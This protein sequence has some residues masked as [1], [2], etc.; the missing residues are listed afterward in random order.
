MAQIPRIGV[1]LPTRGV[2]LK[3]QD[4]PQVEP[5]LMVAQRAEEVGCDSV[6]VGDSLIAKPRLEPL[7]TLAAVA[8]RTCRVRLGTAVLLAALRHP[9]LLAQTAATVDLLS[10]GRLTL[11]AGV[12]GTFTPAQRL[13]LQAAGVDPRRRARRLEEVIQIMRRLWAGD[14][15]TVRT[16]HFALE[17]ISLGFRPHQQHGIPILLACHSG[18]ARDAQCR[19]AARLADGIISITDPPEEFARVREQTL[20]E[21]QALGKDLQHFTAV[22]YMTVNVHHD[23]EAARREAV[24][25]VTRYYG[26]DYWGDRWGPYGPPETLAQRIHEYA[27]AGAT[28]VIV[29]FASDDPLG[30]LDCFAREVLP[31]LKDCARLR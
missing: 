19:R 5:A 18:K 30:Q 9:V 6:W 7:S 1:L 25:W 14:T 8:A 2:L 26:A 24:A 11:A 16:E 23:P 3:G 15:V 28:D 13:E 17:E 20:R 27:A 12:G 21:M 10:G 29:R 31:L 22:Y 4:P